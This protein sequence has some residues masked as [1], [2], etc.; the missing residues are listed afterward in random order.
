MKLDIEQ[1]KSITHGA[2]EISVENGKFCFSRFTKNEAD[3]ILNANLSYTAGIQMEF[4]TDGD[5]LNL[6]VNTKDET[7]V[8]SYFAF[9]VFV[10]GILKGSIC[11][12]K[13]EDCKGNYAEAVYELGKFLKNFELGNGEKSVRIV[14][15]HSVRAE[16]EELEI[17]N[18]TY[19]APLKREKKIVFYGDSI[20][21]GYDAL[22]PS[23]TYAMRLADAMDAEIIN[24][25][26][27]GAAFNPELGHV[28]KVENAD[29]V[30]VAYGTN[31]WTCTGLDVIKS[32]A[33]G[34]LTNLE[35]NYPSCLIYVIA[36]IW[37]KDHETDR[38]GG[39]FRDVE[40]MLEDLCANY[41]NL[42][43]ISG[44]NLVPHDEALFGDLSLHPNDKG[45]GYYCENLLKHIRGN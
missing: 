14:F 9:D 30:I 25:G 28:S 7:T 22:H 1:I 13:D 37:R 40:Q 34:F 45:F 36:P 4:K 6:T 26:I 42:K 35:K 32:S 3:V 38:V 29:C 43:F 24:K 8:R 41:K 20:T 19:V 10:D 23:K 5:K 11:N 15:P 2:V 16:I 12:L 31:D 21:Q 17:E 27:G 39:K 18:A 44:W 33:S